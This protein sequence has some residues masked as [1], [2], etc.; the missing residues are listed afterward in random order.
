M[1]FFV[2]YYGGLRKTAV[3][4]RD[5]IRT[6]SGTIETSMFVIVLMCISAVSALI[7]L[8]AAASLS[9][10]LYRVLGSSA[11]VLGSLVGGNAFVAIINVAAQVMA[12][13]I[14]IQL[15]GTAG[16]NGPTPPTASQGTRYGQY[17]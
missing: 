3:S 1:A 6:G 16:Q 12:V 15:R 2:A 5:I 9:N 8:F 13:I 4:T 17:R 7:G 10:A 11:D 14:L